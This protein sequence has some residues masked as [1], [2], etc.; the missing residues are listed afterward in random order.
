MLGKF[1]CSVLQDGGMRVLTSAPFLQVFTFVIINAVLVQNLDIFCTAAMTEDMGNGSGIFCQWIGPAFVNAL[2]SQSKT[3]PLFL[4][5]Q[6]YSC[7]GRILCG[8]NFSQRD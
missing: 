7:C 2:T 3:Y 5:A 8:G 1:H 4:V 6:R